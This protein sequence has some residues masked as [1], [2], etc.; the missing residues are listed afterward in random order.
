MQIYN[1]RLSERQKRKSFVIERGLLDLKK[2]NML[3][4]T[5]SKEEKEIFN[6]LKP[7]ARFCGQEEFDNLVAGIVKER[8]IRR[9]IEELLS[10]KKLGLKTFDQVEVNFL[11]KIIFRVT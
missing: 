1:K 3:D 5:R 9:R 2:Q 10:Y 4:R 8:E 6:L 7:F 11:K